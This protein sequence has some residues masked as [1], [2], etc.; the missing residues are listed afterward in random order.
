MFSAFFTHLIVQPLF[1][2]LVVIYALLP[3]HNFGLALIIFTVV[4]RLALWPL[5][6]KQLHQ[7]KAM[8]RLQ[9][10]IKKIKAATK[11]NRQQESL[12]L[13]ELYKERG[14]NPLG[15]FPVLIVQMFVLIG[16]YSGLRKVILNPETL[17]SFDYSFVRHLGWIQNLSTNIHHFDNTLLGLVDLSKKALSKSGVYW[18]AMIIAIGSA[19]AQYFTARQLMPTSKDQ[20]GLRVILKEAGQGKQADQSEINAAVGSSTKY[21]IPLMTF[22]ITVGFPA[23]LGLYWLTGG[24]V[25]IVQQAAVLNKDET[26]MEDIADNSS[27]DLKSIPEAEVVTTEIKQ[28]PKTSSHKNKKNKKRKR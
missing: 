28:S 1:N 10:D 11:G 25:A 8:R 22:V 9:P 13:M 24:L 21:F 6:K 3:G 20:R 17:V 16:L 7:T 26:E 2:L 27:R 12:M 15:T 5:V 18:P 23:A 19:I 14:I 4:I